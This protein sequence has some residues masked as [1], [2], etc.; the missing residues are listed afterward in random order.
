MKKLINKIQK[1]KDLNKYFN[2][3]HLIKIK[4][5]KFLNSSIL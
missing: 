2:N 3:F 1:H 4:K 5:N